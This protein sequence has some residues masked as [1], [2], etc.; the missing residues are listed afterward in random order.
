M[1]IQEKN[2][3]KEVAKFLSGIAAWEAFSHLTFQ[4]N[5]M[6][7]VKLYGFTISKSI[8]TVEIILMGLISASLAYYAWF[9]EKKK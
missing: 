8:N 3:F 1:N 2:K 5:D 6:L 4:L 9:S 7:P